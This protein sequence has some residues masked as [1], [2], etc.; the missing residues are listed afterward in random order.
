MDARQFGNLIH[1]ALEAFGR[2]PSINAS[3]DARAVQ[4]FLFDVL[5]QLVARHYGARPNATVAFQVE[6][7]RRRLQA[8][9]NKQSERSRE[10]WVITDVE[11]IAPDSID[12]PFSTM[13]LIGRIDRVDYHPELK[14]WA[15]LD[16]KTGAKGKRPQAAHLSN[17]RWISLQLPL[18]RHMV[19]KVDPEQCDLGYFLVP[20]KVGD[21]GVQCADFSADQLAAADLEAGRVA[22]AVLAANF[23]PPIEPYE[24]IDDFAA[25]CQSRA[26]VRPAPD[27]TVHPARAQV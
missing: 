22:N 15:I 6:Q 20:P 16:Y 2:D 9:A 14:R 23:W 4:E 7:A 11:L 5:D 18:Y 3:V 19:P 24:G 25:I 21:T 17:G 26:L 1:E 8:V 12:V 10:G 13:P 27:E